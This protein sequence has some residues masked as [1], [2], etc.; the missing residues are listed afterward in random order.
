MKLKERLLRY[1]VKCAKLGRLNEI[2][3]E[4]IA[5]GCE[6]S[7]ANVSYHFGTMEKVRAAVVEYAVE[8]EVIEVLYQARALRHP[9][10]RGRLSDALNQ[11]IAA[12][13]R[14]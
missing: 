11:R 4:Q 12:H 9:A 7:E 10:L 8:N 2:T 1:A 6:C 5:A 3:R 14:T 13:I